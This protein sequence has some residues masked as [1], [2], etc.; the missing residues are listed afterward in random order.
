[1]TFQRTNFSSSRRKLIFSVFSFL[2]SAFALA[3]ASVWIQWDPYPETNVVGFLVYYG[4]GQSTNTDGANLGSAGTGTNSI[5][6]TNRLTSR[7]TVGPAVLLTNIT[8][9]VPHIYFAMATNRDGLLSPPGEILI[10]T[11][12]LPPTNSILIEK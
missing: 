5:S 3:A 11:I 1:M 2:L 10:R 8:V 6:I 12:P 7:I 4:P 9:G